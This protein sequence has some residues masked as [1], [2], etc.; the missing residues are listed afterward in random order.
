MQRPLAI[1]AVG[2][3]LLGSSATAQDGEALSR[4]GQKTGD[5]LVHFLPVAT[6]SG[7]S[8]DPY[9]LFSAF[10]NE[11]YDYKGA[12]SL[13]RRYP[14][15]IVHQTWW[16][17][18]AELSRQL[19]DLKNE[20]DVLKQETDKA[21]EEFSRVHG[22]ELKV[23]QTAHLAELDA[24]A[25]QF[26][27][28][29]R[30]GKY[31]EAQ[32]VTKK[33]ETLGSAVYPPY[34]A[35]TASIDRRQQEI[36]DRE[37]ALAS[38]RRSVSFQIHTNRTPTTTAPKFAP[39]VTGTLAGHPFYRQDDGNRK[40]ADSDASFV[41]LAVF[42]GPAGYQ[43]PQVK[44]GHKDLAVKSIVVW[45]WIESHPDHV[46]ADEGAARKVLESMDYDGLAKL[47]EP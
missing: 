45:A 26:A 23:F 28:L 40:A 2:A 6:K 11:T 19:A 41:Y 33:L 43:N 30:Q 3:L 42:L 9:P 27:D 10:A 46:Q 16:F 20:K 14:S 22:A 24:L 25:K 1:V 47:I 38:R 44:I 15:Y 35:L 31:D 34:Q 4:W 36:A 5:A 7:M 13:V 18:D 21:I 37:R 29:S 39:K 8:V 32:A 12:N 17:D